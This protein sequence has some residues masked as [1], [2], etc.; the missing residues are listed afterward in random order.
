MGDGLG[1]PM[2]TL[3]TTQ[4]QDAIRF[5]AT[6]AFERPKARSS[7]FAS[8]WYGLKTR[9]SQFWSATDFSN[10]D[11]QRYA[12]SLMLE[13]T[14]RGVILMAGL[15]FTIQLAALL[16]YLRLGL[17]GSF[18]YTYS[19]LALL[20]FHTIFS[21]RFVSDMR[22]LYM[23][24]AVLLVITGVAIMAV[25]HQ[26][27]GLNA[28][29]MASVVLIFMVIP[30]VP[31]GLRETL[32]VV[33]LTYLVFTLSAVSVDG[34][35]PPETLWTLQ[36]LVIASATIAT[37][38]VMRNTRLRRADIEARYDLEQARG[39]LELLSTRDPLT[40]AWNRRY[41]QS[42]FVAIAQD[43]RRNEQTLYLAVLDVDAFKP[44]NDTFG[45]H[46]GD[47]VLKR[48]VQVLVENLPGTAHVI[49]L[50]GD[51]FAVLD[52]SASFPE[53]IERC[54]HHLK[55]DPKLL[56]VSRTPV[57]VSVGF[58]SVAPNETAD[59]DTLYRDAD[60]RLYEAKLALGGRHSKIET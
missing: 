43:A 52:S 36:F 60:S 13:E 51:E 41:L 19:L 17:D 15:S 56:A 58:A 3:P 49:R 27:G 47:D 7:F 59:L 1:R 54:L 37:L 5:D 53:A 4:D 35:F 16:L 26:T 21:T 31:W 34:R 40:Q 6:L 55:T 33:A 28:G 50:G 11:V 38:T 12:R 32:F 46:H 14:R 10:D 20:S 18:L 2:K 48:L 23:L 39:A 45:H 25:A 57:E 22:P 42:N 30:L 29:L 9:L 44:L 24:G 8:V